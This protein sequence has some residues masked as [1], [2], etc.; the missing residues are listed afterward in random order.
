MS[1][2]VKQPTSGEGEPI[3]PDSPEPTQWITYSLRAKSPSK[4]NSNFETWTRLGLFTITTRA[5]YENLPVQ[6][7]ARGA[8]RSLGRGT[9]RRG[10]GKMSLAETTAGRDDRLPGA[11]GRESPA[12]PHVSGTERAPAMSIDERDDR[13][14]RDLCREAQGAIT[15]HELALI[16]IKE[17]H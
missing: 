15:M 11:N 3:F 7:S 8:S 4:I 13:R 5:R 16:S 1:A 14:T 10:D 12:A 2:E 17:R 6:E 9:D